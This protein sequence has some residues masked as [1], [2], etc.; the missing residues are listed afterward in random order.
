VDS[1]PA[2]ARLLGEELRADVDALNNNRLLYR[3][4]FGLWCDRCAERAGDEHALSAAGR[5]DIADR[6]YYLEASPAWP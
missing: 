3:R 4:L 5:V 2:L 1:K 6:E